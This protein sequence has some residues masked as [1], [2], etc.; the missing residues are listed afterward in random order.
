MDD[1]TMPEETPVA[2][3]EE[4]PEETP[5]VPADET[6]LETPVETDETETTV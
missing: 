6:P 3:T 1:E 5:A 4:T 2:P